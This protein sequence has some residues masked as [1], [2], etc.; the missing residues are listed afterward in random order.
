MRANR[1]RDTFPELRIRRRLHALGMRYRVDMAVRPAGTRLVRPDVAF[2]R[3]RLAIFI[4]G[5]FWHG[6]PHHKGRPKANTHYWGPKIA[7]NRKRDALQT[8]ALEASGWT[9]LR[10]W[11][12]EEPAGVV[13]QIHAT[14]FRLLSASIP[15]DQSRSAG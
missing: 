5:C 6:C 3:P 15:I 11:E 14:Y 1:R 4:D 2:T 7:G 10:F 9:V 12:H 8:A 13:T